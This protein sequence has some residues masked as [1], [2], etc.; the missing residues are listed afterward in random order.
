[1]IQN[2]LTRAGCALRGFEILF[3]RSV[4][5]LELRVTGRGRF[6]FRKPANGEP[7]CQI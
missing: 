6:F 2:S 5:K 3:L 7:E 4:V 1:M